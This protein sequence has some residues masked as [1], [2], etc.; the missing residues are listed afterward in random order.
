[1]PYGSVLVVDD[2][3]SN[4]YVANGMMVPYGLKIDTAPSGFGAI[5]KIRN[6]NKYDIIFMD[7]M[8]PE[9]SGIDTV[10]ILREMGYADPVVAL[11]ANA[12]AG[13]AAMFLDNGFDGFISKPIDMRELNSTLNRLVRDKHPPEVVEVARGQMEFQKPLYKSIQKTTSK[14]DFLNLIIKD[15][16]NAI[17]VFENLLPNIESGG[18]AEI[19]LFTTTVHGLKSVLTN[20]G[21]TELSAA[22][23]RLERAGDAKDIAEISANAPQFA[24]TL[25]FVFEKYSVNVSGGA[26]GADG[27]DGTPSEASD[28]ALD[29]S[30]ED[31]EFLKEKL[32]VI[33]TACG[34]AQQRKA[35]EVL[36][37][38]RSK[39]WP[40]KIDEY[41]GDISVYL[42]KGEFKKVI[43]VMEEL[44]DL[45]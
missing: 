26:G 17:A 39:K 29:V 18:D 20:I 40:H 10:K 37:D 34:Y 45:L 25:R 1:M 42:L 4:L 13:S 23:L 43:A 33:E 32:A 38:I 6:G 36:S 28:D 11:T 2:V 24:D 9:M 31:M 8:M 21:E 12:V 5:E 15:I 44:V 7:H 22:A 19:K 41:L 3:E 35:K 30:E 14:S 16:E 27:A